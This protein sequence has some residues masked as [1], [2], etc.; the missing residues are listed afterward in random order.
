M[1][2]GG[3][4][5]GGEGGTMEGVVAHGERGAE[6]GDSLVDETEPVLRLA[7]AVPPTNAGARARRHARDRRSR[8]LPGRSRGERGRGRNEA[9][10]RSHRA[11]GA[12][13]HPSATAK[14]GGQSSA[15]PGAANEQAGRRV[16]PNLESPSK[17]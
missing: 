11:L 2:G 9:G 12:K 7:E 10:S 3:A 4:R 16:Q 15:P 17:R 1:R 13:K 5:G 6:V 14:P 8:R